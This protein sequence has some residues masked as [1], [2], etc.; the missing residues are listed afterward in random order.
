MISYIFEIYKNHVEYREKE[1]SEYKPGMTI[2]VDESPELLMSFDTLEKAKEKFS[3]TYYTSNVRHMKYS[4]FN[5]VHITEYVLWKQEVNID[6]EG[7]IDYI[8]GEVL[9]VSD[10]K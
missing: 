5:L 2:G 1:F 10:I 3:D 9:D 6:E 7:D 4:P 8:Q